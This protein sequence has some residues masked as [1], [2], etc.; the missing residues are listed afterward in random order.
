MMPNIVTRSA[1]LRVYSPGARGAVFAL[2]SP[3]VRPWAAC[4]VFVAA[5]A[6]LSCSAAEPAPTPPPRPPAEALACLT[7]PPPEWREVEILDPPECAGDDVAGCLDLGAAILLR[8]QLLELR[9]W[10]DI[11]W[12]RCGDSAR[13]D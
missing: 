8:R 9:T 7:W 6:L 12:A 5:W 13:G 2:S 11:A 1:V 4:A 3:T 10:A